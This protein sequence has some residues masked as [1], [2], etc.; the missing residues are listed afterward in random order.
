ML[1]NLIN[2]LLDLAKQEQM[3]FKLNKTFFNMIE[4]INGAF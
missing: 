4:V 2:D 1:I 3:T